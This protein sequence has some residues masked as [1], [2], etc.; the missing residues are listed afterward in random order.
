MHKFVLLG[1]LLSSACSPTA[2]KSLDC[3]K[4]A[5]PQAVIDR[6]L[7]GDINGTYI[8][9]ENC[10]PFSADRKYAGILVTGFE[11]SIFY[12]GARSYKETQTI[13]PIYWL[14]DR[15]RTFAAE[16]T[17][18]AKCTSDCAY[19]VSFVGRESTC[20][21]GFGHLGQYPKMI[22]AIREGQMKQIDLH[23]D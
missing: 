12:P 22:I 9:D 2:S 1:A 21:A 16:E 19:E 17:D 23:Q 13:E 7:G 6:C 11:W 5:A 15:A 4:L 3:P 8:G 14:E 10:Y 18:R 20:R